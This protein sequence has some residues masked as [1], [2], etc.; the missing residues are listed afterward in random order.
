MK[1]QMV[2]LVTFEIETSN[3]DDDYDELEDKKAEAEEKLSRIGMS[4]ASFE[5]EEPIG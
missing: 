3:D 2:A 5:S 1:Y 4:L